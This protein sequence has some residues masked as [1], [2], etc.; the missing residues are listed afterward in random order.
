MKVEQLITIEASSDLSPNA[1]V[2][3]ELVDDTLVERPEEDFLALIRIEQ[4]EFMDL[5]QIDPQMRLALCR[6]R[7]DDC[8]S[9]L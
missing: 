4:A 1:D 5:V 9:R 7:S 3:F 8:K 2:T 6:I